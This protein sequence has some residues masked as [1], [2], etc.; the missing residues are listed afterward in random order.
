MNSLLTYSMLRKYDYSKH[1]LYLN[2]FDDDQFLSVN[3]D[4]DIWNV[5]LSDSGLYLRTLAFHGIFP[6][7]V[8]SLD[9]YKIE[10]SN[11]IDFIHS[12]K[13]RNG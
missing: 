13:Q 5:G 10:R 3:T 4:Y 2:K 9:D 1:S 6:V 11:Y 8:K 12:K 7:N